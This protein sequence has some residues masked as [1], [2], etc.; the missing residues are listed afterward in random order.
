[1][2]LRA[3]S[4]ME[5][6]KLAYGYATIH[7]CYFHDQSDCFFLTILY[8]AIYFMYKNYLYQNVYRVLLRQ[9][10]VWLN[11][12]TSLHV[13]LYMLPMPSYR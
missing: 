2:S 9:P 11:E 6:L 7:K 5:I 4:P 10:S 13:P 1:M 12:T 8:T 3:K